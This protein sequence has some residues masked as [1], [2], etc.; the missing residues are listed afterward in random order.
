MTLL[1][2]D[3]FESAFKYAAIGMALVSPEGRF[4][5]VNPSM[6]KI[7]DYTQ[8]EL[9]QMDFQ[10]ISHPDDLEEDL[11]LVKEVLA[12][13]RDSYSIEKRFFR[14]DGSL[15]W[16][17]LTVSLVRRKDGS[18]KYFISQAQ[19]IT[20]QKRDHQD[21]ETQ[22]R[23]H[24]SLIEATYDGYWDWKIQENYEYMS[25]RFW[26]ILGFQAHEKKHDPKEWQELIFPEDLK[27]A[28]KSFDRHVASHG[29][30]PYSLE[31]RYRAKDG[32]TIW[33]LCRGK[34]VEWDDA[35]QPLRMIGTH[36]DITKAKQTEHI[37]RL[38][39]E[40][41][42]QEARAK[43][44]FMETMSHEIRTPLNGVMGASEI[45]AE[46][47]E[48][49]EAL[50][51]LDIIE[52]CSQTLK[53]IVEDVLNLSSLRDS[54]NQL[55]VADVNI[56][57]IIRQEI[58]KY[59][60][61]CRKKGIHIEENLPLMRPSI[62]TD[63]T[64]VKQ[65]VRQLISNAVKFTHRGTIEV[66]CDV[67]HPS[68]ERPQIV[69]EVRDSGIGVPQD[70]ADLI[71]ESYRQADESSTR[72][73]GGAGLGLAICRQIALNLEGSISYR[74][75]QSGGSIFSF[76]IPIREKRPQTPKLG[77]PRE[78]NQELSSWN[79]VLV[80]EDD[81][82]NQKVITS[83]LESLG[84]KVECEPSGT[85]CLDRLQSQEYNLIF[86]DC[87]MPGLSGL[88]T[89]K[90]IRDTIPKEHQPIIVAVTANALPGDRENCLESGMDEYLAKPFRKR[91]IKQILEIFA[92]NIGYRAS[93]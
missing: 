67:M 73:H 14:K 16:I 19:D 52:N 5:R 3:E 62:P 87:Q 33:V 46:I 61:S 78:A 27:R 79:R 21:L 51:Y 58:E 71:F 26:E 22:Q 29:A 53:D 36:T 54:K 34:V 47:I 80:V 84:M 64:L 55:R 23:V 38:A 12:G 83:L 66:Y 39:K 13:L 76:V 72:N 49:P 85:H 25:P 88:E 70:K 91:D 30:D 41:A 74:P 65:V 44:S 1:D 15:V 86:M 8:S 75:S 92:P 35:G 28:L 18:P 4:I 90:I 11:S 93:A 89:T 43:A 32:S 7:M 17:L 24:Q 31:V 40:S 37:L 2:I 48:D 56:K 42:E 60:E 77:N 6:C 69:I 20:Q 9:Q 57:N 81:I 10:T 63:P 68:D 59:R 50:K 82:N 45:L